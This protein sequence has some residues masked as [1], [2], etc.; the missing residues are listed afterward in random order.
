MAFDLKP[1]FEKIPAVRLAYNI[2]CLFDIPSGT[3]LTGIH[4][5]SLLNGGLTGFTGIVGVAN[6]FK[7]AVMD[8]MKMTVLAR[9]PESTNGDYDT[10]TNV[11]ESRKQ[12]MAEHIEGLSGDNNPI[13]NGRWQI[14][15]DTRY[16]GNEWYE[17]FKTYLKGKKASEKEHMR[18]T[19]FLDREGKLFQVMIPTLTGVD[20]L[21][22]FQTEDVANMLAGNELGD[23]GSNTSFMKQGASKARFL[24]D[25]PRL[26]SANNNPILM[27]AHIGKTIP[28]DPRA[29]PIKKMQYLTNGDTMKGV[30]DQFLFLTTLSWQC[31]NTIPLIND[32][33][34]GPEYPASQNDDMKND[35]DLNLVTLKILRNKNGRSGLV[36]QILVSQ[37]EG[38]LP[39]LSEFHYIKTNDRFGLGGNNLNYYLEF[40][41][42]VKLSRTTVRGKLATNPRLRR[43]MTIAAEM[44]QMFMLWSDIEK[45]VCTPKQLYDDLIAMGYNFDRLLDTRSWWTFNN[46]EQPVPYLSTL[47]LLKMRIGEYVPYWMTAEEKAKIKAAPAV[48][49]K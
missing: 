3:Y 7:T 37:Q 24:A 48:K 30:T 29:P 44:S 41:P 34:K 35:T 28:M 36:M 2:G 19:P 33:T 49:T 47:D 13:L 26:I 17:E 20:S 11:S 6:N 27:T 45:Y 1:P 9:F 22:K 46:D 18:I 16:L 25:L 15:D 10:E 40:L 14:T 8:Y 39:S 38:V 23:S 4:G 42:E 43:G 21:T 5:E 32:T 12:A 31:Y